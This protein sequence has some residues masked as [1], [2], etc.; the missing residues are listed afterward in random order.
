MKN[1]STTKFGFTDEKRLLESRARENRRQGPGN[2]LKCNRPGLRNFTLVE[3]LIT[4]A[5]IAILVATLLPSL[6]QVRQKAFTI[7]CANN[8]K[9]LGYAFVLYVDSNNGYMPWRNASN[10]GVRYYLNDLAKM[11]NFKD[12]TTNESLPG[13][14]QNDGIRS[15]MACPAYVFQDE[16]S[17]RDTLKY[18]H[19][20]GYN[21]YLNYEGGVPAKSMRGPNFKYPSQIIV[22]GDMAAKGTAHLRKPYAGLLDGGNM[23][24]FRHGGMTMFLFGDFH[25]AQDRRL[26]AWHASS[27]DAAK[28]WKE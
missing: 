12:N 16:I 21:E 26:N 18:R 4:I 22:M 10:I 9:T 1:Y 13:V 8:Y 7:M 2:T 11:I 17:E 14:V 5:V 19:T 27:S 15:K 20:M 28:C 24:K 23:P 3:L 6:N 25:V